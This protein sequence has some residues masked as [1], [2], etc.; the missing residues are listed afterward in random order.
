LGI[1]GYDCHTKQC[2]RDKI[3]PKL[4]IPKPF[5]THK[6]QERLI[7]MRNGEEMGSNGQIEAEIW[8]FVYFLFWRTIDTQNSAEKPKCSQN[9]PAQSHLQRIKILKRIV[10]MRNG[11][12]IGSNG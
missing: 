4:A 11:Q 9:E 6:I 7:E 2:K 5:T 1:W 10:Q 12:E 8:Q 3:H